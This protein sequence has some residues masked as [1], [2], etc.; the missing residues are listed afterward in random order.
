MGSGSAASSCP[1]RREGGE[2]VELERET[3]A[4]LAPFIQL[5]LSVD[6]TSHRFDTVYYEFLGEL[7]LCYLEDTV[8][9]FPVFVF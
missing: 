2:I 1:C 9:L 4:D 7:Q 8:V 6:R 3:L 5:A